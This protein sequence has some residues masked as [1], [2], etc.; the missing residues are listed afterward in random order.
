M[1]GEKKALAE[2]VEDLG[3][4]TG[5]GLEECVLVLLSKGKNGHA[6]VAGALDGPR[7]ELVAAVIG[8][9]AAQV[10][11]FLGTTAGG[12]ESEPAARIFAEIPPET[13]RNRAWAFLDRGQ[14]DE[15]MFLAELARGR[16]VTHEYPWLM[17]RIHLSRGDLG[18]AH[19][20]Y[21]EALRIAPLEARPDVLVDRTR[22]YL[23]LGDS[24]EAWESLSWATADPMDAPT[25]RVVEGLLGEV[26]WAM[27][28]GTSPAPEALG[29]LLGGL[30]TANWA[31]RAVRAAIAETKRA[32]RLRYDWF[33]TA[34]LELRESVERI[35]LSALRAREEGFDQG[36]FLEVESRALQARKLAEDFLRG[37]GDYP[38]GLNLGEER[39]GSLDSE[40]P[41]DLAH[42][43]LQ[44]VRD[45]GVP[46]HPGIPG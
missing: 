2:L 35:T 18:P 42:A 20:F 22:A 3:R 16:G 31:A 4:R 10:V 27:T 14:S 23:D 19:S 15:A 43:F 17:A 28:K 33:A 1:S 34:N 29:A 40:D 30:G 6:E 39:G 8:R 24:K 38:H 25:L 7:G 21:E 5:A 13:L 11:E 45:R 12:L 37:T 36:K 26:L 46:A 32:A 41:M 9:R 44:A